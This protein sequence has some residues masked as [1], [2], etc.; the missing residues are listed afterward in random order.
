MKN[1][2]TYINENTTVDES[3]IIT[4]QV[5]R[6]AGIL[7]LSKLIPFLISLGVDIIKLN[8]EGWV[9]SLQ[10]KFPKHKD[11]ILILMSALRNNLSKTDSCKTFI[12]DSERQ[13]NNKTITIS[14]I[15]T[16]IIP[17]IS[18]DDDKQKV[19]NLLDFIES[20]KFAKSTESV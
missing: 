9:T 3:A 6:W 17:F 7:L 14:D 8:W 1:F 16:D 20:E 19:I 13:K 4:S 18:N 15:K 11:A 5:F 10:N 12:Q 2:N